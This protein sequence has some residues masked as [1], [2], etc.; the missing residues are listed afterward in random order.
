MN[1]ARCSQAVLL[2]GLV[3]A[4]CGDPAEAPRVEL[5]VRVDDGGLDPVV[6]DLG[7]EVRLE[8]ARLVLTG[9]VFTQS[10]EA[11]PASFASRLGALL[12]PSALAHPGHFEGGEVTGELPGRHVV[13]WAR[14]GGRT[15]GRATLLTGRYTGMGFRFDAATA[16]QLAADDPLAGH[17][18]LLEGTATRGTETRAFRFLVDLP[19]GRP[20]EG[21]PFEAEVHETTDGRIHLVFSILDPVEDETLFDGIDFFALGGEEPLSLSAADAEPLVFRLRRA[22]GSHDHYFAFMTGD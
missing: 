21:A 14:E 17:T 19:R 13:D 5:E 2:L 4:A 7:Y 9:V 22:V 8:A 1:P 18:G 6:T 10:G 15:L 11:A 12:L 3:G 20:L 16:E